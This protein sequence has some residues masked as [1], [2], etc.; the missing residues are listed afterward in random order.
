MGVVHAESA[1]IGYPPHAYIVTDHNLIASSESCQAGRRVARSN[2]PTPI[3]SCFAPL[4]AE[5]K[6]MRQL[7]RHSTIRAARDTYIQAVTTQKQCVRRHAG[8]F[9][10]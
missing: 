3:P 5:L 2:E 4:G 10:P 8:A 7:L 6:I 9:V 1:S